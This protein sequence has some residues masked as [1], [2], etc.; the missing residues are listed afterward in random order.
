MRDDAGPAY[1]KIAWFKI[2]W[3]RPSPTQFWIDLIPHG[4]ALRAEGDL[5]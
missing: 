2:A 3:F 1:H 5:G 4:F